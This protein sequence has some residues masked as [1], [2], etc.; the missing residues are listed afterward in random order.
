MAE[1]T[2]SAVASAVLPPHAA[3]WDGARS[4]HHPQRRRSRQRPGQRLLEAVV[5][6]REPDQ[7][8]VVFEY[9]DGQFHGVSIRDRAS[10]A[11]IVYLNT[12]DLRQHEGAPGLLLERQG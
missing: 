12:E 5:P 9:A 7:V 8:D 1:G 11:E 10:G 6:G 3:A 2:V 4:D